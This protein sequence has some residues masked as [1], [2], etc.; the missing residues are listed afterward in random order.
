MSSAIQSPAARP[1]SATSRVSVSRGRNSNFQHE[2]DSPSKSNNK[3]LLRMSLAMKV[4]SYIS[5]SI[6]SPEKTAAYEK[7]HSMQFLELENRYL[8]RKQAK[9]FQP[10]EIPEI[11]QCELSRLANHSDKLADSL[12]T[13]IKSCTET[14][15]AAMSDPRALRTALPRILSSVIAAT[16]ASVG[17]PGAPHQ[18]PDILIAAGRL[19]E[20]RTAM[21]ADPSLIDAQAQMI[22][23]AIQQNGTYLMER[24]LINRR[25]KEQMANNNQ[26][27]NY[28]KH[29]ILNQPGAGMTSEMFADALLGRAGA[30]A[31]ELTSIPVIRP[32]SDYFDVIDASAGVTD[33]ARKSYIIQKLES[34][35]LHRQDQK[36]LVQELSANVL[37]NAELLVDRK[38]TNLTAPPGL[39]D[40]QSEMKSFATMHR[41]SVANL[42]QFGTVDDTDD[43]IG[44]LIVDDDNLSIFAPSR[45]SVAIV[46]G[47]FSVAA[48]SQGKD[49]ASTGGGLRDIAKM[50]QSTVRFGDQDEVALFEKGDLKGGEEKE[51][52]GF[53]TR[54]SKS[55]AAMSP[56]SRDSNNTS[57]NDILEMSIADMQNAAD[58]ARQSSKASESG[59]VIRASNFS[60]SSVGAPFSLK[61][62]TSTV[63]EEEIVR[64]APMNLN[65]N[66]PQQLEAMNPTSNK[67]YSNGAAGYAAA[68][69]VPSPSFS[70][71]GGNDW[72]VDM[73]STRNSQYNPN[74]IARYASRLPSTIYDMPQSRMSFAQSRYTA[75]LSPEELAKLSLQMQYVGPN[76]DHRLFH[77]GQFSFGAPYEEGSDEEVFDVNNPM[78]SNVLTS[79]VYGSTYNGMNRRASNASNISIRPSNI[80]FSQVMGLMPQF[81]EDQPQHA[82]AALA[83]VAKAAADQ[84]QRKID[85]KAEQKRILDEVR[86]RVNEPPRS[87]TMTVNLDANR[88][89]NV[90]IVKE[91]NQNEENAVLD[92]YRSQAAPSMTGKSGRRSMRRVSIAP[93]YLQGSRAPSQWENSEMD[94]EFFVDGE[95]SKENQLRHE[96]EGRRIERKWQKKIEKKKAELAGLEAASGIGASTMMTR[97]HR[98][99]TDYTAFDPNAVL[100]TNDN[101][102]MDPEEEIARIAE[103]AYLK[104]AADVVSRASLQNMSNP[105]TV[106]RPS[107]TMKSGLYDHQEYTAMPRG[108]PFAL[109]I[110][111]QQ[112]ALFSR[113]SSLSPAA[114]TRSMNIFNGNMP[115]FNNVLPDDYDEG[116]DLDLTA[117]RNS[118]ASTR[119]AHRPQLRAPSASQG[120]I[121][122]LD[123]SEPGYDRVNTPTSGFRYDVKHGGNEHQEEVE[124]QS[125][126]FTSAP[127]MTR[128]SSLR[129]D[130]SYGG[131]AM[132]NTNN[133]RDSLAS[134]I[135]PPPPSIGGFVN[136]IGY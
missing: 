96:E 46:G 95:L 43:V 99:K 17:D 16:V 119:V 122:L 91:N 130:D 73:A 6:T 82:G 62:K 68:G 133:N 110:P 128:V 103:E 59:T 101:I 124:P 31:D 113:R 111:P 40:I 98:A 66:Y 79:T 57:A 120:R 74:D 56:Q 22:T 102:M 64:N 23:Q 24:E 47:R 10:S 29:S 112:S 89:V 41:Q 85:I 118:L 65:M 28:V 4:P 54:K 90:E 20:I 18:H 127:Q 35:G 92:F 25:Y 72:M 30:T 109:S 121:D 135:S 75:N 7:Y 77:N 106:F 49:S 71:Y 15:T 125:Q 53:A 87:S 104:G 44:T 69:F 32:E 107:S 36:L 42:S 45:A 117:G 1:S 108:Q 12:R 61:T 126:F 51:L 114:L 55:V 94:G 132:S 93:T 97:M 105:P 19:D 100:D 76:G 39:E 50:R 2:K 134:T 9:N 3:D 131:N 63:L 88:A 33:M 86:S 21:E 123:M 136:H 27:I 8:R 70:G 38:S 48:P 83:A 5:G 37:P 60:A 26:R 11:I 58:D 34:E 115:A 80:R 81:E 78:Y 52:F 14:S 129:R 13:I 116:D 84:Q 67:N